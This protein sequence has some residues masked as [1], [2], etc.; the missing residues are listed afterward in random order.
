MIEISTLTAL[1]QDA[2]SNKIEL[3][4]NDEDI[5]LSTEQINSYIG[6]IHR[7]FS[8]LAI[9]PCSC[10]VV[11]MPRTVFAALAV[12][13]IISYG[14]IYVPIDHGSPPD[15]IRF[16]LNQVQPKLIVTDQPEKILN[17]H[18]SPEMILNIKDLSNNTN[19]APLFS[20]PSPEDIAGILYTSGSTGVPKGIALSHK[21]MLSFLK[22]SI[23]TFKVSKSDHI[24]S[25][26]P[27]HFDLSIFDLFAP[28]FL[29]GEID[30]IPGSLIIEPYRL[31]HWLKEKN[32]TI[33]YS[34]PSQFSYWSRKGG[35]K[36]I[37]LPNLRLILFAGEIFPVL[38][39]QNLLS[40]LPQVEFYN[41]FGPTE[42]NVCTFWKVDKTKELPINIPIGYPASFC[43]LKIS[44][45]GTLLVKGQ[46]LFSG[47][48]PDINTNRYLDSEGWFDTRDLVSLG[49]NG[50]LF[51][52]GRIDRMVKLNGYRIELGEI[53]NQLSLIEGVIAN[54]V[55]LV[56][57]ENGHKILVSCIQSEKEL[58]IT[59]IHQFL[60]SRLL[61]YML[62]S[63]YFF[64]ETLPRLPNGKID[65]I[66][67]ANLSKE[68]I[69][70]A[71]H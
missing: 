2:L 20:C 36:E 11:L 8:S 6:S 33:W 19:E 16:I 45:T 23:A 46:N 30:F 58:Q 34:V 32:I 39:L 3:K 70:Y 40:L 71:G 68:Q 69:Q 67:I 4:L 35:L 29:G 17:N 66:K 26:A 9:S 41:L 5:T 48:W 22:W 25:L 50:K 57:S 62:P 14:C 60:S 31:T 38:Q 64:I 21:A 44:E 52:H 28:F 27:F 55:S 47:Y 43:Q 56:E 37:S 53:E 42:T 63:C 65:L 15:R 7:K 24:A 49:K 51:Y 54:V 13:S 59:A 10:I 18:Y 61:S 12:Y 1:I